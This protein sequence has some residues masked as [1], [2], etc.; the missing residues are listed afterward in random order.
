MHRTLSLRRSWPALDSGFSA[1]RVIGV[2]DA[3]LQALLEKGKPRDD[4]DT[5]QSRPEV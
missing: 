2:R 3:R 5:P 4:V 1:P